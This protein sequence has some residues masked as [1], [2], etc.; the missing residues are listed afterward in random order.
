MISHNDYCPQED[1]LTGLYIIG[2]VHPTKAYG[3][4]SVVRY[5]MEPLKSPSCITL[6]SGQELLFLLFD[7]PDLATKT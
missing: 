2:N 7:Y 5:R 1:Y 6:E 4:S 3:A